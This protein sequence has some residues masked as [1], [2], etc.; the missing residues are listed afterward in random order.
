MSKARRHTPLA[1]HQPEEDVM[2][3]PTIALSL[4]LLLGAALAPG[5][6]AQSTPQPALTTE[7][8]VQ[9]IGV[10]AYLYLY[11][12]VTMDLTRTQLTNVE[13]GKGLGGPMNMF[14]NILTFPPA[15]MRVVVR[16]NFDTLYSSAWLDLTKEPMVVS[17]HTAPGVEPGGAMSESTQAP[18]QS[19]RRSGL[20]RC[21]ALL[22]IAPC[23]HG[24]LHASG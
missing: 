20:F 13:P 1:N 21:S 3:I 24:H 19:C 8:E 4:S 5:A 18:D 17:A 12:L 2:K 9:A 16:P 10:D 14:Q 23:R 7:Q 11:S 6:M 22:Q 15:D